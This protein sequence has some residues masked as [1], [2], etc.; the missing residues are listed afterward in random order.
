MN[1]CTRHCA[2]WPG[3][4]AGTPPPPADPPP[5]PDPD[6]V[7]EPASLTDPLRLGGFT[8]GQ[9]G[10]LCDVVGIDARRRIAHQR[11][12]S[13]L[14][15][16]AAARPLAAPPPSPSFV[17]DDHTPVEFSLTFP[18]GAAPVLRVL[19]DPGCAVRALPD[20]ART[21]WAAVGRLAAQWG[22]GLQGLTRITDLFL[23]PAPHGPLTLWCALDLRPDGPPGLKLYLNPGARG[24]ERSL[25][26]VAEA[27]ARLGHAPAFEPVRRHLEPRFPERAGLM[28]FALDVG[29]WAEP[30]VKVYVVH[31]HATAADAADAARLVPGAS[32]ERV[33]DVC[34]RIGGD[35]P[36]AG[37]PL[38]SGYS[39]T[40]TDTGRPTGHTLYVPVRACVRDDEEA[41]DHAVRLLRQYGVADAPLDRALAALTTRPLTAGR[42]LI[43]YLS[44]V[45]ARGRAP[46]ITVYLSSEAYGVLP[47]RGDTSPTD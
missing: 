42:G 29:P 4:A 30:R 3:R 17:A 35:G 23:P 1:A 8:A 25:E 38:I 10:R 28:F 43:S 5:P 41:R 20:N 36:F 26:T 27:M 22:V 40:G 15:G 12:L 32:P 21:A 13:E 7:T 46:R 34:R 33:A 14:L 2:G 31:H 11:V 6:P 47:P 16:P 19:A 9:L 24:A 44:L 39:F 45:Q 37:L 18:V